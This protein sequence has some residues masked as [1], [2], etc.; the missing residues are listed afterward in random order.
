M[1]DFQK[2]YDAHLD[3][4]QKIAHIKGR[5]EYNRLYKQSIEDP[6]GFWADQATKYL[7]WDKKWD[8]VLNYDFDEARIEWFGGG[9]IN[10]AYN[11]LDR[12][13]KS[14]KDK[15]A[16]YWV[17][18]DPDDTKAVSYA[19]L[20][21][22]VNRL[23]GALKIRG[24]GKGDRVIVYMP[25]IVELPIAMLACARIGAIHC[26]VFAGFSAEALA[27]RIKNCNAKAVITADGSFRAGKV[28][29]LKAIVDNALENCPDV[30][31]VIVYDRAGGF[32]I[33]NN[34]GIT[35][36]Y[37]NEKIRDASYSYC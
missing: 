14:H 20:H 11:C 8:S 21:S 35:A 19:E 28:I 37:A 32:C 5:E 2:W 26:V 33:F 4:Y 18:D 12:H 34:I 31:N 24:I 3:K 22:Q 15:V 23:A 25:M 29:P 17:G 36:R 6:E 30:K 27:N 10:A 13:L 7:S 16:Y 9:I 1:A